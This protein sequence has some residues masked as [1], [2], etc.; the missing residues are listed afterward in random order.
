MKEVLLYGYRDRGI[1]KYGCS[2]N[3]R[4]HREI[5]SP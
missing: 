3:T 4:S 5:T 1:A 2:L